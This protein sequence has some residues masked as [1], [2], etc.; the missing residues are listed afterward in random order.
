MATFKKFWPLIVTLLAALSPALS[1]SV[2]G[3]WAHHP[4]A[5]ALIAGIWASVKWLLPSPIKNG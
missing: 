3:F 5:V 1:T 2:D 4:A